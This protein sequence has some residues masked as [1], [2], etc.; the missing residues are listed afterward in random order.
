[1]KK[2][3]TVIILVIVAGIGLVGIGVLS[4]K[5]DLPEKKLEITGDESP[6]TKGEENVI[7][8]MINF[9]PENLVT[10]GR[11]EPGEII[12]IDKVKLEEAGFVVVYSK[13][14]VEPA[15]I[16]GYSRK[17]AKG[18]TAS[19]YINLRRKINEN[20]TIYVGL[21]LDD[22]DGFFE[23]TARY[24]KNIT[25]ADGTPILEEFKVGK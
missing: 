9:E 11:I 20:E 24:D 2:I 10:I 15:T 18:E 23:V 3:L 14:F 13:N 1:M 5:V 7:K 22:G 25:R 4:G 6:F 17:L 12:L 8:D 19:V 21:R 16:L